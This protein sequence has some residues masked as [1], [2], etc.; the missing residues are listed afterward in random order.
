MNLHYLVHLAELGAM[1]IHPLGEPATI[2][3]IKALD[4]KPGHIVLEIGCGT[5]GTVASILFSH[6]V[7]IN[8][9]DILPQM[10]CVGA[11]RLRFLRLHN[12]ANLLNTQATVLPFAGQVYDRV[13][14]ESVLGIQ[15]P[16][17]ARKMMLEVFRVLRNGGLYVANEAI[18]K[19]SASEEI[20]AG[21]VKATTVDFGLG[22][23]S[24]QAWY[25]EDWLNLMREV[26]FEIV[27][28]DIIDAQAL[29]EQGRPGKRLRWG[30]A[31]S[32]LPSLFYQLRG[33]FIPRLIG[34]R[35]HYERL[36]QKHHL[37]GQYIEAR[38][39]VLKKP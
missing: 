22:Q 37:A 38:L 17:A 36:V 7:S 24:E 27:S 29:A 34:R 6:P 14:T 20:I 4:L 10:L 8:G 33:Y 21:I 5:A 3:L 13:Y 9:V 31:I 18:W 30:L 35:R 25:Q 11:R 19:P 16:T 2:S 32:K 12:K 26:G 23:A 39:F 28:A 1:H 15:G